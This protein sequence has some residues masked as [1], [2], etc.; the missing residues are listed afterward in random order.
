[1]AADPAWSA[2]DRNSRWRFCFRRIFLSLF[3]TKNDAAHSGMPSGGD[4]VLAVAR[5]A[6]LASPRT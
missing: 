1:M 3:R 2:T 5:G 6:R 4:L